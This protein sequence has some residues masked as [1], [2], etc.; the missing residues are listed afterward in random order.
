[1]NHLSNHVESTRFTSKVHTKIV[2]FNQNI[3]KKQHLLYN[4]IKIRYKIY[5]LGGT[6]GKK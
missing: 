2:K 4:N 3:E 5:I 6:N 1:M